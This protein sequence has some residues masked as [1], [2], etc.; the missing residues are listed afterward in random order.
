M[1]IHEEMGEAILNLNVDLM[2]PIKFHFNPTYSSKRRCLLK[3]FI[4]T[5]LDMTFHPDWSGNLGDRYICILP[6]DS[7]IAL[8][9]RYLDWYDTHLYL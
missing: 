5:Y 6:V 3:K 7:D 2:P 8:C 1:N 4:V 9:H